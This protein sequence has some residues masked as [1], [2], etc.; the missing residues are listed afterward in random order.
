[1]PRLAQFERARPELPTMTSFADSAYA[2]SG[3]REKLAAQ[4]ASLR[5]P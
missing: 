2:D 4:G 1:M 3:L 5:T